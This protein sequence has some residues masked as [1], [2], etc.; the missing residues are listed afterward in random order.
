MHQAFLKKLQKSIH[1]GKGRI[2]W[3]TTTVIHRMQQVINTFLTY[4]GW[5][6]NGPLRVAAVAGEWDGLGPFGIHVKK[7]G[8]WHFSDDEKLE[9]KLCPALTWV[10]W[11]LFEY[12][13]ELGLGKPEFW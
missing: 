5:Q 3:N 11:A 8:L 10:L 1:Y 13:D 4:H 9:K 12:A 7:V 6:S 2:R